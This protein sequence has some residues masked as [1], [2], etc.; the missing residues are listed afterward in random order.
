MLAVKVTQNIVKQKMKHGHKKFQHMENII[1][2]VIRALVVMA[3]TMIAMQ[4]A[5]VVVT[6]PAVAIFI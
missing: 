5:G 3:V 1:V 4:C 2:R 6:I